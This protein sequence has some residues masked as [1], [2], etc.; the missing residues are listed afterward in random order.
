MLKR[1]ATILLMG[2]LAT[3]TPPAKYV[4]QVVP[5]AAVIDVDV[6]VDS[7]FTDRE[8]ANIVNAITMW[9]RSL[10]GYMTWH[11]MDFDPNVPPNPPVVSMDDL[12]KRV[13]VFHRAS[14]DADWVK[15]WDAKHVKEKTWILGNCQ[16]SDRTKVIDIK[17][18][19]S[20]LV[21][22]DMET[23][24][25]AHEFGH[26][27]GMDH[28]KDEASTLSAHYVPSNRCITPFDLNEFC[29]KHHCDVA[30]LVSSCVDI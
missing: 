11:V 9:R 2:F 23:I 10:R 22:D 4:R 27:M 21:N 1:V 14:A 26:A 17:L 6:Y 7:Q 18:I 15:E 13:V 30:G 24:I 19:E 29:D 8:R 12:E 28:V 20:R 16:N 3:C 5:E 25:A